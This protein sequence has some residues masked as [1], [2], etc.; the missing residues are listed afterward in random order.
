MNKKS[1]LMLTLIAAIIVSFVSC[2]NMF[3]DA[4]A[5]IDGD[6]ITIEEL[7]KFYYVQ[8]KMLTNIDSKD[9]IDKLA[10]N[11]AYANHPFLNKT[12]FLDH[13]IA[14]KVLYDKAMDDKSIDKDEL[15]TLLE[16]V[17]VQTAAQYFLSKKLKDK[18]TVTDEE[19]DKIYSENRSKFAGRTAEEASNYIKQQIF[20]QKSRQET[21]KYIAELLAEHAINKDGFKEYMSK[22]K[23]TVSESSTA[24]QTTPV[25]Q[26]QKTEQ[27]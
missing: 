19:V 13:L 24:N 26:E 11:P 3:G 20:A 1:V 17:K 6:K 10:D 5:K 4:A 9:E 18:I 2:K 12:N 25:T 8:N 22:N 16:M 27:K 21:N 14:Q 23:K 15:D 7:N